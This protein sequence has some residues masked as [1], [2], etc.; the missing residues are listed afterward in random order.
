MYRMDLGW[1]ACDAA[2]A[3]EPAPNAP[4]SSRT[5]LLDELTPQPSPRERVTRIV[6]T[7]EMDIIPRL[8]DA[9]R[10]ASTRAEANTSPWTAVAPAPLALVPTAAAPAFDIAAFTRA[11]LADDEAPGQALVDS[12]LAR[13]VALEALCLGLFAPAA[14]EL[15]RMWD[16][17]HCTFSDVTVGV[18]HLQRLLRGAAM[19]LDAGGVLPAEG[20]RALLLPAPGEAHTFGIT[21]VAEFFRRDG[22]DVV[23]PAGDGVDPLALVRSEWFDVIGLSVGTDARLDWL[24]H[25]VTAL[26]QASR[27]REL[28]VI[29]GGPLFSQASAAPEGLMVDGV[30]VDAGA[31]PALAASLVQARARVRAAAGA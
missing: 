30:A 14:R 10:R 24:R 28:A 2:P 21:V 19:P 13:G 9:H 20:R 15:G 23:S 16:E 26:R 11:L 4:T 18:G 25:G 5:G 6:R 1:D 17:D 3:C 27:N 29:V 8:V 22:W 7:I 12:L 31:A